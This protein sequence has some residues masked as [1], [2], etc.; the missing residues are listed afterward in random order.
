[1][2]PTLLPSRHP[3]L[4]DSS[5]KHV[6]N[7][8]H[9]GGAGPPRAFSGS[10]ILLFGVAGESPVGRLGAAGVR[11]TAAHNFGE[12][13]RKAPGSAAGAA[14]LCRKTLGWGSGWV[15]GLACFWCVSG[16][17]GGWG[18]PHGVLTLFYRFRTEA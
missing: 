2:A 12:F 10:C 9:P 17:T 3:L 11:E 8:L 15:G 5:P 1:M 13:P 18:D 16:V 14:G 7:I 6:G 4:V